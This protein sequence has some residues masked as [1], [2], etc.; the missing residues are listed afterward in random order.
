MTCFQN[1]SQIIRLVQ[2]ARPERRNPLLYFILQQIQVA[3]TGSER[4]QPLLGLNGSGIQKTTRICPSGKASERRE[5]GST[6]I[7]LGKFGIFRLVLGC[8]H[9]LPCTVATHTRKYVVRFQDPFFP[10]Y[11]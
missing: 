11:Y 10:P 4:E 7:F 5:L 8:Q 9:H 6:P 2:A 1:R 3:T